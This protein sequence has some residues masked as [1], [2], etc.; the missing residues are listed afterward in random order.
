MAFTVFQAGTQLYGLDSR[1]SRIALTLPSGVTLDSTK[2]A[3]FTIFGNYAVMVNSPSRP[4]TIDSNYNVRVLTPNPPTAAPQLTT[5]AGGALTGTNYRVKQTY[6]VRDAF[7]T[8]ISE[9][10]FS[11]VSGTQTVS[12]QFLKV[13][14]LT[15]SSD[16][17]T[18]TQLYRTLSGGSVYFPWV[19][20]Q[21][22]TQTSV[23]DDLSDAGISLVAADPLGSAPDMSLVAEFK[24]R[25]WGVAKNDIDNL[26]YSD[27]GRM[28]AW[29]SANTQPMPRFGSDARGITGFARRRDALG[30]G[31]ENGIFQLTGTDDT[32][33]RIVSVSED[34]GIE[35]PDSVAIY[36]NV[37]FFL[38]KDGIY[39]L[40]ENGVTCISDDKVRRWFTRN[41][42]FN[43][44]RL[45]KAFAVIDPWRKKYKLF[46]TSAGSTHTDCWIDY[47]FV[48][49]KFWGPHTSF[50]FNPTSAFR[51][52]TASGI[53]IPAIGDDGGFVRVDRKQR[54]DDDGMA[55]DMDVVTARDDQGSPDYD[56]YFGELSIHTKPLLRGTL[57]VQSVAGEV[58]DKRTFETL[59]QADHVDLT[60]SRSRVHRIGNGKAMRLRFRNNEVDVD[61]IIRGYE[62]NPV[63]IIG[64]R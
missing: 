8:L 60:Q 58:D 32:N 38:W 30:I 31:R 63:R 37:A 26:R 13:T 7:G 3:R 24:G 25:L 20:I 64:R 57:N 16:L 22:N 48:T 2:P 35:A 4:L 36:K 12:A 45:N 6:R 40:D 17:V 11:P 46:L 15:L 27:V 1:G 43:L 42:T 5:A 19:T 61:P 21:G 53:P 14:G 39:T 34:A 9:S 47:D 51:M 41:D 49:G 28:Y 50:A 23:Q 55:V 62:V 18:E 52:H 10:D 33:F 56:K 44:S 59:Q 54:I 29:P